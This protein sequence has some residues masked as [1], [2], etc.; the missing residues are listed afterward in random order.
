M[1]TCR[2]NTAL[3]SVWDSLLI[4][5]HPRQECKCRWASE[6]YYLARRIPNCGKVIVVDQFDCGTRI[7]RV[8]PV[9]LSN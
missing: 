1:Q 2:E 7:L 4:S 6:F 5:G 8:I 3:I 9:P